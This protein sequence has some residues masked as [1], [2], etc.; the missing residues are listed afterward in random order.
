MV[1]L[2]QYVPFKY[3]TMFHSYGGIITAEH[4]IVPLDFKFDFSTTNLAVGANARVGNAA[5]YTLACENMTYSTPLTIPS[6]GFGEIAGLEIYP[7][8]VGGIKEHAD[9]EQS[10]H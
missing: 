1:S 9:Q 2:Y 7:G 5:A 10:T 3:S 8:V 6:E 4:V